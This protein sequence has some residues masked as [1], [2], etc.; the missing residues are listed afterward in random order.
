MVI[1]RGGGGVVDL[2][3]FDSYP[4][5]K[6]IAGFPIPVITGIGHERDTSVADIVAF[7]RADT[8][9]AAAEFLISRI[10][11]FDVALGSATDRLADLATNLLK[12][13]EAEPG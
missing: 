10:M 5:A 6:A 2:S 11:L 1:I 12:S 8:P 13:R 9:T 4:L 3:C 7:H